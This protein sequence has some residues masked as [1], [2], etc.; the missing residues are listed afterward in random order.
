MTTTEIVSFDLRNSE[1]QDI[2]D[3][4]EHDRQEDGDR[5]FN[6]HN[7]QKIEMDP[8]D[9]KNYFDIEVKPQMNEFKRRIEAEKLYI[10]HYKKVAKD[11]FHF[12]DNCDT[13]K[14]GLERNFSQLKTS[15]RLKLTNE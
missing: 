10:Q 4:P 15:N 8:E 1:Y 7:V 6:F 13:V 5:D 9:R 11:S 3:R 2:L 14:I 12:R